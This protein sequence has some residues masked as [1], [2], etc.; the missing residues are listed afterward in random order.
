MCLSIWLPSSR[1]R[2]CRRCQQED[3]WADYFYWELWHQRVK[4]S[5]VSLP[6]M[7][8]STWLLSSYPWRCRRCTPGRWPGRLCLLGT[9]TPVSQRLCG[10]LT[11]KVSVHMAAFIPSTKVWKMHTRRMTEQAISTRNSDTSESK[12]L[13]CPY[14]KCVCPHDRLHPAHWGVDDAHK[15]DDRETMSTGNTDTGKTKTL[16]CPYL[17]PP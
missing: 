16:R 9:L 7:C 1:P 15:E 5:A 8:L 13:H 10:G 3:D 11:W 12:T 2:R 6:E 17:W 4:D 14:L